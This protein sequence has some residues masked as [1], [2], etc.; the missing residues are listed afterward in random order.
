M[1]VEDAVVAIIGAAGSVGSAC[2]KILASEVKKIILIDKRKDELEDLVDTIKK[3]CRGSWEH[4]YD[5]PEFIKADFIITVAS[6]TEGILKPFHIDR[7]TIIIDTAQPPN[8]SYDVINRDDVV[9]INSGIAYLKGINL[10][11]NIGLNK[12]EIYA[13]LG[14][15]LILLW[16]G[17]EGNYNL[18]KVNPEQVKEL[19]EWAPR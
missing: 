1:A 12:E 3:G 8:V 6:A 4:Y 13:C 14:E 5:L 9:V 7:G 2:S 16:R 10:N 19:L 18:G 17:W 15:V 11:M